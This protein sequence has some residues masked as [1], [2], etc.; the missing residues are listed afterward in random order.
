MSFLLDIPD[1]ATR[2]EFLMRLQAYQAEGGSW[3]ITAQD[4]QCEWVP[5]VS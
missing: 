3:E 1:D 4:V 5:L 2:D